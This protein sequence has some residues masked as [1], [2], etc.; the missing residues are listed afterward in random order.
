MK[1]SLKSLKAEIEELEKRIT[2]LTTTNTTLDQL[3]AMRIYL[4]NVQSYIISLNDAYTEHVLSCE[5]YSTKIQD[6]QEQINTL[7]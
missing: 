2:P 5:E 1:D 4:E 7:N 3:I 6:L